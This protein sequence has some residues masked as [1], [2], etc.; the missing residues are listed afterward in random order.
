MAFAGPT[1]AWLSLFVSGLGSCGLV[2][3][4]A[5]R[6]CGLQIPLSA[7]SSLPTTHSMY[8]SV[9]HSGLGGQ[10]LRYSGEVFSLPIGRAYGSMFEMRSRP[11]VLSRSCAWRA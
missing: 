7:H 4:R 10:F 1:A 5:F 3:A 8:P 11:M 2:R 9:H 6:L